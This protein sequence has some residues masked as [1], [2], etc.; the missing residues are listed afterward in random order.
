M[1]TLV[2]FYKDEVE[3]D[4]ED[5]IVVPRPL[6]SIPNVTCAINPTNILDEYAKQYALERRKL[7][8]VILNEIPLPGVTSPILDPIAVNVRK[9]CSPVD[10]DS[11]DVSKQDHPKAQ[12]SSAT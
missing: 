11:A 3:N 5:S 1:S 8:I 10:R 12:V 9:T 4:G 2:I 6:V 7:Q